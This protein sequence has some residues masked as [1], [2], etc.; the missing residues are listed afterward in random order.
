MH[1]GLTLARTGGSV[2]GLHQN[3]G[4]ASVMK[5]RVMCGRG[6]GDGSAA[7]AR[8]TPGTLRPEVP[9]G[10]PDGLAEELPQGLR[11]RYVTGV[12]FTYPSIHLSW[13]R[14]HEHGG[15]VVHFATLGQA[16]VQSTLYRQSR[17]SLL[18][19]CYLGVYASVVLVSSN[20][21]TSLKSKDSVSSG[22]LSD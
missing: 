4:S 13:S 14:E 15:Y 21:L 11:I 5:T 18:S 2:G 20:E 17:C 8:C 19:C 7:A 9:Y 1:K 6:S 3:V 10:Q 16:I 12:F 22:V